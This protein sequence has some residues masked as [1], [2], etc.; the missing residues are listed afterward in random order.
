[1]T[2]SKKLLAL[3]IALGAII[4]VFFIVSKM[5]DSYTSSLK[6]ETTSLFSMESV[7]DATALSWEY[8]GETSSFSKSDGA[9]Q[10]DKDPAFP[11]DE[12]KID[13]LLN[14]FVNVSSS[15]TIENPEDVS[16]YGLDDPAVTVNIKA[17]SESRTF[18]FGNATDITGEYYCSTGDG[19]VYLVSSL[20]AD[21]FKAD[22]LSVVKM[23]DV[24]DMSEVNSLSVSNADGE[25][26]FDHIEDAGI[27][28]SDEYV[29][30]YNNGSGYTAL[31]NELF[32][33]YLS[34][35]TG[36]SFIS[37][38]NY[39]ASDEELASYG[40]DDPAVS[41]NVNYTRTE[42]TETDETDEDGNIIYDT[43]EYIEDFSLD[44]GGYDGDYCYARIPGSNMVYKVNA[45]V[46]DTYIYTSIDDMLPDDVINLDWS[47]VTSIDMSVDGTAY[48][49]EHETADTKDEN[50]AE[51]D[52]YTYDGKEL[53]NDDT[54]MGSELD[55]L[56]SVSSS[57]RAS[58]SPDGKEAVLSFVFHRDNE[59]H[60]ETTLDFYRYDSSTYFVVLDGET[61]VLVD[62]SSIDTIS[63]DILSLI[64]GE[65]SEATAPD[66][67]T[68]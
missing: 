68:A 13:D 46:E 40:L 45:S 34:S 30:Y 44:L 33:T 64:N 41:L 29:W 8:D 37:C 50:A 62:S 25:Y 26:T 55:S 58:N 19:N 7:D 15:K 56:A 11:V 23:E 32:N 4:A 47:E 38:V 67:E 6:D 21:S 54:D 14:N 27:C 42:E 9:W 3:L 22:F 39:N 12:D 28:Y 61:T 60:P 65:S 48:T 59:N 2:R 63:D 20:I 17:G 24:P 10:Y 66:S 52:S 49:I 36:V 53:K 1:M 57:G 16:Q 31:D 5:S 18:E 35:I 43:K 51:N